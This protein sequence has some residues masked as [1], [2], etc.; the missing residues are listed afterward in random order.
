MMHA[1]EGTVHNPPDAKKEAQN[2]T[3][4]LR[5]CD[6]DLNR[7]LQQTYSVFVDAKRLLTQTN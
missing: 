4:K 1:H 6:S 3:S 2:S 5:R 7:L